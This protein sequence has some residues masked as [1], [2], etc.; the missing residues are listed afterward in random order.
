M[1]NPVDRLFGDREVFAD[2]F[3]RYYTDCE[4][5]NCLVAEE[6]RRVVGYLIGCR[7]YLL[8]P[9]VQSWILA[10]W[11]PRVAARAACRQYDRQSLRFV[12]W[13]VFHARRETPAVPRRAGHF[14][15]NLL[16]AW[17]NGVVARRLISSFLARTRFW[18]TRRVFGQIQTFEDRRPARV[19]ERYG[20]RLF[21]RRRTSK[22]EPFG[23]RGVYV[24][25][26][27]KHLGAE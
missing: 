2:F 21:D 9:L 17:R 7:R 24:S 1:G 18:D 19:F 23:I 20:F 3:T 5:E 10:W 12:R 14:H 15:I 4:P 6:D 26:F 27:V 8:Y 22:F 13:F 25:T 11:L 16:P